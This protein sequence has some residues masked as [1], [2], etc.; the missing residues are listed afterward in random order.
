MKG[1]NSREI[2]GLGSLL[3]KTFEQNFWINLNAV[4]LK[5]YIIEIFIFNIL[6]TLKSLISI[7][8]QQCMY[9]VQYIYR[10]T[11]TRDHNSGEFPLNKEHQRE[12]NKYKICFFL[13]FHPIIKHF[14]EILTKRLKLTLI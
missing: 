1:V 6:I 13:S 10:V 11:T 3:R 9:I 8:L 14:S 12:M 2:L 5:T 7:L 4:I